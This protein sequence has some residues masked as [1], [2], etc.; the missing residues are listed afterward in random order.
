MG[1][2]F[3]GRT[4]LAF[5]PVAA[6]FIIGAILL[7][8]CGQGNPAGSQTGASATPVKLTQ[9]TTAATIPLALSSPPV[10]VT[11][12]NASGTATASGASI[13][14]TWDSYPGATSY[15]L[16]WSNTPDFASST[17]ITGV[18]SPY[19]FQLPDAKDYYYF[20]TGIINGTEQRISGDFFSLS[21]DGNRLSV[22]VPF[23][24]I[25][26]L[27]K[28]QNTP[29]TA[30]SAFY[31]APTP[32]PIKGPLQAKVSYQAA[33]C[34]MTRFLYVHST[35]QPDGYIYKMSIYAYGAYGVFNYTGGV[36]YTDIWS[37]MYKVTKS[38]AW[39]YLG[40]VPEGTFQDINTTSVTYFNNN[41]GPG[42]YQLYGWGGCGNGGTLLEVNVSG[43]ILKDVGLN[44][45]ITFD[46][47]SG[48]AITVTPD[49]ATIYIHHT[50]PAKRQQQF[51]AKDGNN[52][53]VTNNAQWAVTP[54]IAN[55]SAGLATPTKPGEASITA[56]LNGVTSD[57]AATLEVMCRMYAQ[58]WQNAGYW[59][60]QLYAYHKLPFNEPPPNTI[61]TVG[62]SLTAYAMVLSTVTDPGM[63]PGMLDTIMTTLGYYEHGTNYTIPAALTN[64]SGGQVVSADRT[65]Y[66]YTSWVTALDNCGVII[67]HV[68]S[69]NAN[70]HYMLVIGH[71]NGSFIVYD[72]LGF[73]QVLWPSEIINDRGSILVRF[74]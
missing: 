56:T 48:S 70:G 36:Q 54:A 34:W 66:S 60:K 27:L 45:T 16:Y 2:L 31:A 41:P 57:P 22:V 3:Q 63:N 64:L 29:S 55:I 71:K 5:L 18:C 49:S 37:A 43:Q 61:A 7:N 62:C 8:S 47:A 73:M 35:P 1:K 46:L 69:N 44:P 14:V 42:H 39:S 38:G 30:F 65:S 68:K 10:K 74:K 11:L 4:L 23:E 28:K 59:A 58:Y 72:P 21:R 52:T 24:P 32:I 40:A 15:N 13:T 67:A 12:S 50:D 9:A 53:D 51:A 6:I 19:T 33:D 25:Y 26:N 17:K 20:L